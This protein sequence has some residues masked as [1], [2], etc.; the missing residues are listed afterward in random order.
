MKQYVEIHKEYL[1]KNIGTYVSHTFHS[2]VLEACQ[3]EML[4]IW[5]EITNTYF[6]LEIHV[7]GG[8]QQPSNT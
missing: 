7:C 1:W 6:R 5:S 4:V 3:P 8:R 2:A